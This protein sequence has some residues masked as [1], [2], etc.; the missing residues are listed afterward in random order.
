MLNGKCYWF[1]ID[2]FVR[3]ELECLRNSL[4]WND[5]LRMIPTPDIAK[6]SWCVDI[7]TISNRI[8]ESCENFQLHLQVKAGIL[9]YLLFEV[10]YPMPSNYN[11]LQFEG[12]KGFLKIDFSKC[13][14]FSQLNPAFQ[15][16]VFHP[17]R[18]MKSFAVNAFYFSTHWYSRNQRNTVSISRHRRISFW[19]S[20]ML[21]VLL[22]TR[23]PIKHGE[24]RKELTL[25]EHQLIL[26][27]R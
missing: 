2:D 17:F 10:M 6:A 26:S 11:Q 3:C 25:T 8:R 4:N 18:Q 20:I 24:S 21:L 5:S 16:A 14:E 9:D 27:R 19:Q 7:R 1:K 22:F 15:L 13:V 12:S 23:E